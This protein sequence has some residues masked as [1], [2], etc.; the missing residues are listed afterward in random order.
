MIK[1]KILI[2]ESPE[3]KNY[4]SRKGSLVKFKYNQINKSPSKPN[5]KNLNNNIVI[6]NMPPPTSNID[7]LNDNFN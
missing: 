4:S 6:M 3:R 2:K 7:F 5:L 1:K